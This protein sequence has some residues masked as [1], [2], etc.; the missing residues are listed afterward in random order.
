MKPLHLFDRIKE[1]G[2]TLWAGSCLLQS[3][4]FNEKLTAVRSL[5]VGGGGLGG[6]SPTKANKNVL[7]FAN[8]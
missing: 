1:S 5:E 4:H 7:L 8:Y 6:S 2:N 3:K